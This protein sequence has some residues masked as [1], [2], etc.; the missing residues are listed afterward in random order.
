MAGRWEGLRTFCLVGQV[1]L[2]DRVFLWSSQ[3]SPAETKQGLLCSPHPE[4]ALELG[5]EVEG[6]EPR[7]EGGRGQDGERQ[8]GRERAWGQR[9]PENEQIN[10]VLENNLFPRF[11]AP[12]L[13][14]FPTG[15]SNLE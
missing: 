9:E 12:C 14:A 11:Q 4:S 15:D 7:E 13:L 8:K 5:V 1:V 2:G 6:R 10:D 3:W